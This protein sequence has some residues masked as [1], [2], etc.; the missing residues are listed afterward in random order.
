MPM[1]VD[2]RV[3]VDVAQPI[4]WNHEIFQM[5]V[6]VLVIRGYVVPNSQ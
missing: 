4:D 1:T 2:L 3:A 6:Q 5:F